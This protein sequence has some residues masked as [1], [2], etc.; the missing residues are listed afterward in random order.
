MSPVRLPKI[1]G[2][3]EH[4]TAHVVVATALSEDGHVLASC[5]TTTRNWAK[6]DLGFV[7]DRCR[8]LYKRHYPNGYDMEWVENPKRHIRCEQAVNLLK[9]RIQKPMKVSYAN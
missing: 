4:C 9:S 7:S 3:I 8:D 2:F 1:Y 6:H 5:E